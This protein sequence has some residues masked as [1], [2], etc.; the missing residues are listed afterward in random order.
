MRGVDLKDQ[1]LQLCLLERKRDSKWHRKHFE[2]L[3]NVSILNS[4]ICH[5]G[6]SSHILSHLEYWM[7][8]IKALFIIV[9]LIQF[10]INILYVMHC[11]YMFRPTV[12]VIR[13]IH[14]FTFTL[15]LCLLT[16]SAERPSVNPRPQNL[17][18]WQFIEKIPSTGKKAKSQRWC[19][20]CLGMVE[21]RVYMVQSGLVF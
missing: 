13:Y 1:K 15:C 6:S 21:R 2:R 10:S 16:P 14:L 12:A 17:L 3:L 11:Y 9:L 18:E 7:Q 5:G 8:L 19:A 20:V 4:Y